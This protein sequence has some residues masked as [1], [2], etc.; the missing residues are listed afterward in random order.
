M[1]YLASS[2][3]FYAVLKKSEIQPFLPVSVTD[4]FSNG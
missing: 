4:E 3:C 2:S 1:L